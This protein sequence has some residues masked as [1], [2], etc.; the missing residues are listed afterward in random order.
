M[1]TARGRQ[2][3]QHVLLLAEHTDHLLRFSFIASIRAERPSAGNDQ[4]KMVGPRY[5]APQSVCFPE[6]A[7]DYACVMSGHAA[8]MQVER[9]SERGKKKK[10]KRNTRMYAFGSRS[11]V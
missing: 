9:E 7:T 2:Q 5:R 4:K 11:P 1:E 8:H 3:M 6:I 10:R